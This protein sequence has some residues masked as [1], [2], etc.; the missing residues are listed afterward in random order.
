MSFDGFDIQE[1]DEDGQYHNAYIDFM[2]Q[3]ST[4]DDSFIA[5]KKLKVKKKKSNLDDFIGD[6]NESSDNRLD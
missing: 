3:N 5:K 6:D 2:Q 4:F 1:H